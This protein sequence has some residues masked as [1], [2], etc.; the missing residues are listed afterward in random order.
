MDENKLKAIIDA[1]IWSSLG[2]IQS[3]TTGERQQAMEYYLRRPYG[4][5][6]EGKSQIITG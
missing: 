3:E 1:E 6:V 5:E 4:N 2:F